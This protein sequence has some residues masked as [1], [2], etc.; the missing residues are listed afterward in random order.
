MRPFLIRGTTST[1]RYFIVAVLLVNVVPLTFSNTYRNVRNNFLVDSHGLNSETNAYREPVDKNFVDMHGRGT[2]SE[3]RT[4]WEVFDNTVQSEG[5]LDDTFERRMGAIGPPVT[6][7]TPRYINDL[8]LDGSILGEYEPSSSQIHEQQLN[9]GLPLPLSPLAQH[10]LFS[11][12]SGINKVSLQ[13]EHGRVLVNN[14]ELS[15]L[16]TK[17]DLELKLKSLTKASE[18]QEDLY[19]QV[20]GGC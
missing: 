20:H 1:S 4:I 7:L 9:I 17:D 12:D 3:G 14:N 16:S 8:M 13:I 5:R 11:V 18:V 6:P 19:Q 10:N 15:S 2:N